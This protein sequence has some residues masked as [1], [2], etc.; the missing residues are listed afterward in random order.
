MSLTR[1][2]SLLEMLEV[3]RKAG[4]DQVWVHPAA[5]AALGLPLAPSSLQAGPHPFLDPA[6][7]TWKVWPT[8][9]AAGWEPAGIAPWLVCKPKGRGDRE[10]VSVA[11]VDDAP[12]HPLEPFAA[13]PDPAA[14][15][16]AAR[17]VYEHLGVPFRSSAG[18]TARD[19]LTALRRTRPGWPPTASTAPPVALPRTEDRFVWTRG[20]TDIERERR[21]IQV[22]DANALYLG[23][24][25]ALD[26]GVGEPEHWSGP[27]TFF[28][29]H[30][31]GYWL[32][33]LPGPPSPLLP[34][35]FAPGSFVEPG[36]RWATTPTLALAAEL[37]TPAL[38][39]EAYVWPRTYR[40][41][42]L[43]AEQLRDARA[44]LMANGSAEARAAL[45]VVKLAY[46]KA[47]GRFE[48]PEQG[49]GPELF[50]PDWTAQVIAQ[51]RVNLYRRLRRLAWPPFAVDVDAL[52][53][54]APTA[55]PAEAARLLGLPLGFG[56]G[57]FKHIGTAP[58]AALDGLD[59][60][61][62]REVAALRTALA[63]RWQ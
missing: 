15:L 37:G 53:F 40:H 50:R 43:W 31:A 30:W 32:A 48:S 14:I 3:A 39:R 23:T 25:I 9:P 13:L 27:A 17:L 8:T 22:Y 55:D 61:A 36:P 24:A 6:L 2:S 46:V 60:T 56:L 41:L 62:G 20:L 12:D 1:P 28:D 21:W 38:V 63:E 26:L 34:D 33:E 59:L 4:S 47:F 51:A 11:F 7:G 5:S 57:Q 35:P 54:A 58:L 10:Q 29:R 45:A 18:A 49:Y 42:R 44:G 19:L 52:Y 16:R